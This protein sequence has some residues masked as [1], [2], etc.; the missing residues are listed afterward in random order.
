MNNWNQYRNSGLGKMKVIDLGTRHPKNNW[1]NGFFRDADI[2]TLVVT[3][4]GEAVKAEGLCIVDRVIRKPFRSLEDKC[5]LITV[6]YSRLEHSTKT[7]GL[8][9][10][11]GSGVCEIGF[12]DY[13]E[14]WN[15]VKGAMFYK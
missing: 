9:D 2:E 13:D 1:W 12:E 11:T 8:Y 5:W 6:Q 7:N 14:A 10:F 4:S 15:V 3:E